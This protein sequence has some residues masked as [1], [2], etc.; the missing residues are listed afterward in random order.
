MGTARFI[1]GG[2]QWP[3]SLE[4]GMSSGPFFSI[5]ACTD[6]RMSSVCSMLMFQVAWGRGQGWGGDWDTPGDRDGEGMPPRMGAR[7]PGGSKTSLGDK[8]G[9]QGWQQRRDRD[10]VTVREEGQG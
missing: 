6:L 8:D 3:Y 10:V 1:G 7:D 9:Q 5:A 4:K 2:P